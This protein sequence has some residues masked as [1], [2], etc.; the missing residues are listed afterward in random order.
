ML[1]CSVVSFI[2][3]SAT[4]VIMSCVIMVSSV[5]CHPHPQEKFCHET[6]QKSFILIVNEKESLMSLSS[7]NEILEGSLVF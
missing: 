5:S 2:S 7:L 4:N 1:I 6:Y 3:N